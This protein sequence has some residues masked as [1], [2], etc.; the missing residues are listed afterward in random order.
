MKNFFKALGLV[1]V[2]LSSCKKDHQGGESI[3]GPDRQSNIEEAFPGQSGEAKD[4]TVADQKV[5]YQ[6]IGAN[7][8]LEGDIILTDE[9]IAGIAT[10]D[11]ENGG[12]ESTGRTALYSRWPNGIV[13]YAIDPALPNQARAIDA[14]NY[15]QTKT[16]VRFVQRSSQ[17]NYIYFVPG[18]GCSSYIGMINSRQDITLATGCTTGNTIHEIG[19]AIGLWHEQSRS[20]RDNNVTIKW[21]NI[22]TG[23][24]SNF[25]TYVEQKYDGLTKVGLI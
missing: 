15:W 11:I 3:P 7:N 17:S 13:Y 2:L 22:K 8:V 14:M 4:A 10:Q 16:L 5:Y 23:Y 12:T 18:G 1:I 9:Q 24:E 6:K 25:K 19:H 21:S 20:D